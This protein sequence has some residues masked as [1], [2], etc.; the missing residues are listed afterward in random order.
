MDMVILQPVLYTTTNKS[1]QQR[2]FKA[3]TQH[4][5]ARHDSTNGLTDRP[6]LIPIV[7]PRFPKRRSSN[8][9]NN[10]Q[11]YSTYNGVLHH[12]QNYLNRI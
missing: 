6:A 5:W 7:T 1:E 12:F 4:Y 11:S 2:Q 10:N 3:V 8:N 9:I